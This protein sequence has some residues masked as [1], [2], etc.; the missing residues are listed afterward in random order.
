MRS[1]QVM[2]GVWQSSEGQPAPVRCPFS[3]RLHAFVWRNWALVPP[4]EDRRRH[5]TTK[6][7]IRDR[8][9]M[10]LCRNLELFDNCADYITIIKR[11]CSCCVQTVLL[12]SVTADQ[13]AFTL[14]KT[15]SFSLNS[16]PQPN[17]LLS[18]LSRPM[19]SQGTARN[20]AIVQRNSGGCAKP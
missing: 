19:R 15:I 18:D 10:G 1:R 20:P 6:S 3:D 8:E 5:R 2:E 7:N 12:L 16:Q 14:A 13:L 11:N 4:D 9:S 17:A